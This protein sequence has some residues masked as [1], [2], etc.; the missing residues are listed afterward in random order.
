MKKYLLHLFLFLCYNQISLAQNGSWENSTVVLQNGENLAG[1][2]KYRSEA[3]IY[4]G[5]T[6]QDSTGATKQF[7]AKDIQSLFLSD[8]QVQYRCVIFKSKKDTTTILAAVV[9]K[10]AATLYQSHIDPEKLGLN[11]AQSPFYLIQT[12]KGTFPLLHNSDPT[13]I[14]YNK[15][16]GMLNYATGGCNDKQQIDRLKYNLSSILQVVMNYNKCMDPNAVAPVINTKLEIP[17]IVSHQVMIGGVIASRF[18]GSQFDH[19]QTFDKPYSGGVGFNLGYSL[20]TIY[21]AISKRIVTEFSLGFVYTQYTADPTN[22]WWLKENDDYF[23]GRIK[24]LGGYIL[25]EESAIKPV[26]QFGPSL[27]FTTDVFS[28]KPLLNLGF[29]TGIKRFFIGGLVEFPFNSFNYGSFY[30][31]NFKYTF[32]QSGNRTQK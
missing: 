30:C 31:L 28:I 21:P 12:S 4:L 15:F 18:A 16:K 7:N 13:Q 32:A 23:A 17:A 5:F 3:D 6:F 8:Y 14:E 20:Q 19:G 2:V 29:G 1:K 26:I 10:G 25:T 24:I 9:S 22:R 27:E 11:K